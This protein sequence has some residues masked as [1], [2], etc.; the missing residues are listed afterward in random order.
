M[1]TLT[2]P[3]FRSELVIW[4]ENR[5]ERVP[6]VGN[7]QRSPSKFLTRAELFCVFASSTPDFYWLFLSDSLR[8][9]FHPAATKAGRFSN[10]LMQL[11][12]GSNTTGA[13]WE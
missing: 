12:E 3:D 2:D 11:V 9:G 1:Y 7:E 10:G 8:Y 5:C 6:L 13:G 4:L